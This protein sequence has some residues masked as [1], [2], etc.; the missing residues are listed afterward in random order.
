MPCD[1]LKYIFTAKIQTLAFNPSPTQQLHFLNTHTH[2]QFANFR[3]DWESSYDFKYL[4][5]FLGQGSPSVDLSL[6][7]SPFLIPRWVADVPS[8][9][10]SRWLSHWQL[11]R[12]G[13]MMEAVLGEIRLGR[14]KGERRGTEQLDVG[15]FG[16]Y[17][18]Q[19]HE[20]CC[21]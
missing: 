10:A 8:V 13:S 16:E 14:R 17:M 19:E 7:S 12:T 15:V 18:W 20:G 21:L 4:L 2:T 9:P 11:L 3:R 6:R 1:L 5:F